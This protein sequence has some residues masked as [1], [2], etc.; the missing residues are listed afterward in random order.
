MESAAKI[1]SVPIRNSSLFE[2]VD[3]RLAVTPDQREEIYR[4]RYKAYL[5]EGAIQESHE[6]RVVDQ[7]DELPN[8]WIFGVYIHDELCSSVR[9]SVLKP[10]WR[11][12]GAADAFADILQPRLDRGEVI[13]DPGRFVADPVRA[14]RT[15]ELPY[16]TL[17]LCYMACEY[18][19]ADTAL[20]IVRP[21]HQAFYRRVFTH[22]TIA[23]PRLFPGF[24]KPVALMAM[25]VRAS[26]ERVFARYPV[27][28]S[29]AFERRMCFERAASRSPASQHTL[30]DFE[31]ALSGRLRDDPALPLCLK[32]LDH[33]ATSDG[34]ERGTLN[35]RVLSRVVGKAQVDEELLRALTI[36]TTLQIVT[37]STEALLV[38]KGSFLDHNGVEFPVTLG[39]LS[40]AWRS[41]RFFHPQTGMPIDDFED[42]VSLYFEPSSLLREALHP[43]AGARSFRESMPS[44][45]PLI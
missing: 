30:S 25:D 15:F 33:L 43:P 22:E 10:S 38:P 27:M 13:I 36:M 34:T 45:V 24:R 12:S 2:H 44:S 11:R 8:S 18:F 3:Y 32:I 7:Y 1:V 20:A 17:R 31:D 5:R 4:L 9:I 42:R 40:A 23:E 41:Q 19:E 14:R 16:L 26:R 6:Q 21:E 29:T 37:T 35:F 28:R 39:R